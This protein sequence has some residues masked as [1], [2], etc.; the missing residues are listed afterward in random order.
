MENCFNNS[1]SYRH[2][3]KFVGVSG[4]TK[5]KKEGSVKN[6][7]E[8]YWEASNAAQGS[9]EMMWLKN[10]IFCLIGQR[11]MENRDFH[12]EDGSHKVLFLQA[13]GEGPEQAFYDLV[14]VENACIPLPLLSSCAVGALY[15]TPHKVE[16]KDYSSPNSKEGDE[17]KIYDV[18]RDV[19]ND[20]AQPE[21][22]LEVC[23]TWLNNQTYLI[24]EKKVLEI[25]QS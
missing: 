15:K 22:I 1:P 25:C 21:E 19:I 12:R 11:M 16:S 5:T 20:L 13:E 18:F 14:V 9:H 4:N 10:I 23:G 7:N 2:Q 6:L 24:V 17:E 8:A 3:Q